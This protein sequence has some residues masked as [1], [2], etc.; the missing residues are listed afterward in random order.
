MHN[1]KL[2]H[3]VMN[4]LLCCQG[5]GSN[6]EIIVSFHL[7]EMIPFANYWFLSM[8]LVLYCLCKGFML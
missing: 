7:L 3:D 1:P 4:H 6:A 5:F 8:Y 2:C